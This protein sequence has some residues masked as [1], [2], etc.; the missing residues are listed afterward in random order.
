MEGIGV[1]RL[2]ESGQLWADS[3]V[4]TLSTRDTELLELLYREN[5]DL[6]INVAANALPMGRQGSQSS[7]SAH[8]I[9]YGPED[10][11]AD[12]KD[13][14]NSTGFF[15]QDPVGASRDVVYLNPQRLFNS[16]EARTYNLSSRAELAVEQEEAEMIDVLAQ[17]TTQVDLTP[18]E[19][20]SH[21]L[22]PLQL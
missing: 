14:L 15:L 9:L 10:L 1:V 2:G 18:T 5:F 12:L 4:A 13:V 16:E 7:H 22:T 3:V 19:G 11:G 6:E 20:S 17:F 8:V 21:L